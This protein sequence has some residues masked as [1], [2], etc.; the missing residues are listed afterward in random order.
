MLRKTLV[1][2]LSFCLFL[3][4][5]FNFSI[6]SYASV[7]KELSPALSLEQANQVLQSTPSYFTENKGQWHPDILFA[8]NTDFGKVAFA[9]DAIYYNLTQQNPEASTQTQTIV[10]N[11]PTSKDYISSLITTIISLAMIRVNGPPNVETS[12]KSPIS[13]FGKAL[14]LPISLLPK[15]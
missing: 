6:S 2:L 3:S 10:P 13:T 4:L 15:A 1:V 11:F 12:P 14:I 7:S 8:G 5:F 9:K